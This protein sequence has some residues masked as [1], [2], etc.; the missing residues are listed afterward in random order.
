MPRG[1]VLQGQG[2]VNSYF[3]CSFVAT[4]AQF[5]D[6]ERF[7]AQHLYYHQ[8]SLIMG[9]LLKVLLV[10]V[11]ACVEINAHGYMISPAARNSAWRFGYDTPANYNDNELFCGG[12]Q[13]QHSRNGGNCGVCGDPWHVSKPR[14]HE[15][16]GRFGRGVITASYTEG[17]VI[18]VTLYISANH[19][20]YY[21]FR[22][23]NNNNPL[24][25]ET[26]ECLNK[27]LLQLA[28]GTGTRYYLDGNIRGKHT[29]YVQLS[30]RLYCS[31]CVLQ[32]KWVAENNW[33]ICPDGQGR[34]GCGPQETFV[35]CADVRILRKGQRPFDSQNP[36]WKS[37]AN[38]E[39]DYIP[40]AKE[41]MPNVGCHSNI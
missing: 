1:R 8:F 4:L 7:S 6:K 18:P 23:C 36:G 22:L 32:W 30:A 40:N 33:G 34:M 19:K 2:K 11:V 20:G 41:S 29:V 39:Q 12:R 5:C 28:D 26:Q 21:E 9:L 17:Q 16:G 24:A 10:G 13:V 3:P 31:H 15:R 37:Y 38:T 27:Q 25:R 35:N 14:P